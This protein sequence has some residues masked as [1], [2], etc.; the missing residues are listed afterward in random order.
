M[1]IADLRHGMILL[2]TETVE[3]VIDAGE[4]VRVL[5]EGGEF[6][7]PSPRHAGEPVDFCAWYQGR[8][9][10]GFEPVEP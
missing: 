8:D 7:F 3:G 2:A 9:L 4:R 6:H 1:L 5:A 10:V